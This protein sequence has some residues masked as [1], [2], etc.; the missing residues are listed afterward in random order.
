MTASLY[1]TPLAVT[2][3]TLLGAAAE[4]LGYDRLL[5][6]NT[7]KTRTHSLFNQG[8]FFY[9]AIPNM[10]TTKLRALV[11]KFGEILMEIDACAEIFGWV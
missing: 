9:G 1:S 8:I 3:L 6:A 4:S 10:K 5:R 11:R 7:V 2:L